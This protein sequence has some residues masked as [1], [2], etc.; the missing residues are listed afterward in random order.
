LNSINL[1]AAPRMPRQLC[2]G[3]RRRSFDFQAA[4]SEPKALYIDE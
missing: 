1:A 4:G 2:C 3:V